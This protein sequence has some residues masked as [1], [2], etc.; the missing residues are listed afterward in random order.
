MSKFNILI[1]LLFG[2]L[3]SFTACS[4][5]D[6]LTPEEL[7]AKQK[8]EL[9]ETV[10]TNFDDVVAKKWTIKEFQPSDA[11]VAS[12]ETPDGN[13][14]LTRIK[15]AEYATTF[16]M[17]LSFEADGD[18]FKPKVKIDVPE[19][20]LESLALGYLSDLYGFELTELWVPKET[21]LAQFRRIIAAP[22][23]ADALGTDDITNEETGLCI[24][25][26]EM[27]DFSDLSYDDLVLGQKKLIEGNDDKIYFNED[28][29]LTV[30][31]TSADFGVSK[32]IL[33][34]VTE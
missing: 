24:F 19:N 25:D 3:L 22:L 33:E 11:M 18:S 34:E 4:D 28:G 23:A 26:I 14:A 30:E 5:D 16:K 1:A 6:E 27:S 15:T 12:S 13:T 7:E 20:E 10:A 17:I 21:Y 32:L 2:A 31:S 9:L 29:T 8:S